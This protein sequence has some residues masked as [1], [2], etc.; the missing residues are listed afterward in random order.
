MWTDKLK[1]LAQETQEKIKNEVP[2]AKELIGKTALTAAELGKNAST[3][4]YGKCT[5][6]VDASNEIAR[7]KATQQLLSKTKDG[8]TKAASNTIEIVSNTANKTSVL[9]RQTVQEGHLRNVFQKLSYQEKS[10]RLI[11]LTQEDIDKAEGK[12]EEEKINNAIDKLK[13]RDKVGVTGEILGVAGGAAAGAAAAGAVAAAAGAT[14]IL[15]STTLG[16]VLGG[17]F[18]ASTPVGWVVGSAAAAAA[19]GYG[20]TKLVHSGGKQDQVRNDI[21]TRLYDKIDNLRKAKISANQLNELKILLPV[22][23]ENKLI[24]EEQ[25]DRMINLINLNKLD[26]EIA[27]NRIKSLKI[28][29]VIQQN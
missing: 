22:A 11:S 1:K 6:V 19:L 24:T 21:V 29:V 25:A 13:N 10:E 7:S 8:F 2:H 23:I 16:S 14:T 3:T 20:I 15:G 27:L 26:I 18:V 4:I 28:P 5:Q 9:F 12:T 17:V